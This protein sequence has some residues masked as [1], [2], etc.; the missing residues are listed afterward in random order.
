MIFNIKEDGDLGDKISN[1]V[2]YDEP[3]TFFNIA[4]SRIIYHFKYK[5]IFKNDFV[6]HKRNIFTQKEIDDFINKQL[7]EVFKDYKET[8]NNITFV[9]AIKDSEL[10]V[11]FLY[12]L[13]F[14]NKIILDYS[15]NC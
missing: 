8:R 7:D 3:A 12:K 5:N 10:Y 15:I 2:E 4:K 11:L 13:E 9:A 14:E 6:K 1:I